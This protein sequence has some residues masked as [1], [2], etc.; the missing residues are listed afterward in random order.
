M[1]VGGEY[2]N[3]LSKSEANV[4][5]RL[6]SGSGDWLSTW[7]T[8]VDLGDWTTENWHCLC[9]WVVWVTAADGLSGVKPVGMDGIEIR[10]LLVLSL[11]SKTL[12]VKS[13][14][15]S[16][17]AMTVGTDEFTTVKILEPI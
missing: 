15:E 9:T 2:S 8:T 10:C 16:P 5:W 6:I 3:S 13:P 1:S 4:A 7:V 11:L 12:A 17:G 14:D